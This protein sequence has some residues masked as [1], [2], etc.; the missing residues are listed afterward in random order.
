MA[1]P[2]RSSKTSFPNILIV[3]NSEPDQANQTLAIAHEFLAHS[4]NVRVHI[5]SFAELAP[6]IKQLNHDRATHYEATFHSLPGPTKR[7]ASDQNGFFQQDAFHAHSSL[8]NTLRTYTQ[9]LPQSRIPWTGP[10]YVTLYNHIGIIVADIFPLVIVVDATLAPGVDVCRTLKWR[11]VLV[12]SGLAHEYLPP[13]PW[14]GPVLGPLYLPQTLKT[15]TLSLLLHLGTTHSAHLQQIQ[16]ARRARDLPGP[17]PDP[18]FPP[19]LD[20]KTDPPPLLLPTHRTYDPM[21]IIPMAMAP[22]IIH[23]GPITRPIRP[24]GKTHPEL[25]LWLRQRPTI[26]I[27]L[28]PATPWPARAQIEFARAITAVLRAKPLVQVLW[29]M[30]PGPTGS[31][32]GSCC[33]GLMETEVVR[34]KATISPRNRLR[35]Y[36]RLPAETLAMLLSGNVGGVVHRGEAGVFGEGVRAGVPQIVLPVYLADYEY[37]QRVEDLG[38]GVAVRAAGRVTAVQLEMAMLQVLEGEAADKMR[39]RA[40]AVAVKL[41]RKDGRVVAHERVLEMIGLRRE[42]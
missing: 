25:A 6:S 16:T 15:L 13:S 5:A 28:G 3:T 32:S 21:P 11:H 22:E 34:L 1:T 41:F 2:N 4:H 27:T 42:N 31:A 12:G 30:R 19:P 39:G 40:E 36:A 9:L 17:I 7:E 24:L 37:A 23:C 18:Y 38:V 14:R 26:L 35:I 20:G 10:E 33:M 29:L 8:G